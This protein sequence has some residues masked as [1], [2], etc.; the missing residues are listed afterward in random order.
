MARRSN[1]LTNA[2]YA[3]GFEDYRE[4]M[5]R[6]LKTSAIG[7]RLYPREEIICLTLI[8][9]TSWQSAAKLIPRTICVILNTFSR[10]SAGR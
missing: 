7:L 3:T 1:F 4:N 2:A 9:I 5:F 10:R 8:C 6:I